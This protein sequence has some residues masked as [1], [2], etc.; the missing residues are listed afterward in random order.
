MNIELDVLNFL[1]DEV[2]INVENQTNECIL[3]FFYYP[4]CPYSIRA[5]PHFNAIA[6]YFPQLHFSALNVYKYNR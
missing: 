6:R 4:W 3:I 2:N 5:A 1:F